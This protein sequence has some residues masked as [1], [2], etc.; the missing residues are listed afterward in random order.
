MLEQYFIKPATIDRFRGSWIA[1]EIETYVAW[2]VD[3]GYGTKSVWRRVPIGFAFGEFARSEGRV[4]SPI[5]RRTSTRSWPTVS[6][7]TMRDRLDEADGEGGPRPDRAVA[8][9]RAS[10]L[11]AE[12][13][14]HRPSPS[15][16][17]FRDSSTTWSKSGV[18]APPRSRLPPPPRPL[19]GLPPPDRRPL[20][21]ASSR[22]RSSAPTSVERAGAGLAKSTVRDSAGVL[23]VFLRYAHREGVLGSDLS[24][25]VGWPQVYRL[26]SIPRSIS[27]DDVNRVLATVD[28]RTAGGT[29]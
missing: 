15:P 3:Q 24:G 4:P 26:S 23:R 2:L 12:V 25:A 18:C 11:R 21:R 20:D 5:C 8:L 17:P 6:R 27:W 9:G 13:A 14:A 19:R 1:T 28:R 10:R 22:R 29:A 7:P 16:M